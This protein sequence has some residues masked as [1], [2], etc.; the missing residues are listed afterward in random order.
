[1]L[2]LRPTQSF[3][4]AFALAFVWGIFILV[5]TLTPSKHL[6]Q[7]SLFR[8]DKFIHLIIFLALTYFILF[9]RKWYYIYL[10][11]KPNKWLFVAIIM[12][13]IGIE[14]LQ[15][16]IPSRSADLNDIIANTTGVAIGWV[17]FEMFLNKIIQ[18]NNPN[19][20]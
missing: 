11:T 9:G 17:S 14:G 4:K 5:A 8:F 20:S 16:M 1:V 19:V 2:K 6:P 15:S 12:Y 7:T 13:G 18:I 10:N 3:P